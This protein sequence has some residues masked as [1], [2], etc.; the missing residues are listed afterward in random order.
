MGQDERRRPPVF[1]VKVFQ[2]FMS[3]H[4]PVQQTESNLGPGSS[5]TCTL[6]WFGIMQFSLLR[7]YYKVGSHYKSLDGFILLIPH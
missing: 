7:K 2:L 3:N 6:V 1:L 4:F 5:S